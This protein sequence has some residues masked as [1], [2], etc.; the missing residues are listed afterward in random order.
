MAT[1]HDVQIIGANKTGPITTS[2]QNVPDLTAMKRKLVNKFPQ[3]RG[4]N[5]ELSYVQ[6]RTFIFYRI[7]CIVCVCSCDVLYFYLL[8]MSLLT[9]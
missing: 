8:S 2:I 7:P 9:M 3:L 6:N 1:T 4:T 5:Y